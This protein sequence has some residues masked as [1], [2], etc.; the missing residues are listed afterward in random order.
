MFS[1][2]DAVG[3]D[4]GATHTELML[5]IDG[6]RLIE[7]NPRLVGAK[8]PRVVGYALNRSLHEEL[9][10]LHVGERP[11]RPVA[12]PTHVGVTRWIV[13]DRPGIL[14]RVDVPDRRDARIRSVELMKQPGDP[15]RPPV[16][17]ADRIGCV[18]A[19]AS[20]S[21]EATA[22]ADGFVRRCHVAIREAA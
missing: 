11:R 19:C 3:F 20:T 21:E 10:R 4:W 15:V 13:A 8:I 7:V 14:D 17:N 18:I 16:E 1:V 5:T 9:I 2:L 12:S 22:V 6:P